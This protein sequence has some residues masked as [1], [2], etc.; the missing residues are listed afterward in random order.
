MGSSISLS[1][2]GHVFD[3]CY[4]T[5]TVGLRSTVAM[6]PANGS[7]SLA[8]SRLNGQPSH[9]V[10][11]PKCFAPGA[12]WDH[13]WRCWLSMEPPEDVSLGHFI[14]P[15]CVLDISIRISLDS[16]L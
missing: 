6:L 2:E 8:A 7:I 9:T 10:S 1:D 3:L 15:R 11:C 5:P 13:Y 4:L 12:H 16:V 14:W